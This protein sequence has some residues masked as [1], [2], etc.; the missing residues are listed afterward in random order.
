MNRQYP[1]GGYAPGGYIGKCRSC[2]KQLE[3]VDKRA[4]Q[5]EVCAL[6]DALAVKDAEIAELKKVIADCIKII[7]EEYH[8]IWYSHT[9]TLVDF[10]KE[11][12]GK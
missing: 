5:C 3:F 8:T 11:V 10:L 4:W 12:I 7:E 1:I 6:W 2:D 9:E